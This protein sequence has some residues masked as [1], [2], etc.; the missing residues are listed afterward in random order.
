MTKDQSWPSLL[1]HTISE[2]Y[3]DYHIINA[4]ISGETTQGG[5]RRLPQAL[6]QHQPKI[7][8]LELGANDGLRGFNLKTMQHNLQQMIEQAHAHQ[9][10]VL[11][12]GMQIPPNYGP[13]YTRRFAEIYPQLATQYQ[14]ELLPFLLDGLK[15]QNFQADHLHPNAAAQPYLA[16]QVWKKLAPILAATRPA[17]ST[18]PNT[19]P[20]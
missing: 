4:S 15:D 14:L 2:H 12:I 6:Q 1:Q 19:R 10:Q 20:K 16:R 17:T 3:P 5:L 9:S 18:S 7:I 11:L 8:I 13:H